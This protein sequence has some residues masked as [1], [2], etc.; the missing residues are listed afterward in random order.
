MVKEGKLNDENT[1]LKNLTPEQTIIENTIVLPV[2][3]D[4]LLK[5]ETQLKEVA[6]RTAATM[7]LSK[8]DED[9]AANKQKAIETFKSS[10]ADELSTYMNTEYAKA[11]ATAEQAK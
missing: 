10:G 4:D 2:L 11:R 5:K 1:P 8:T 7:I 6:A 9:F 3:T